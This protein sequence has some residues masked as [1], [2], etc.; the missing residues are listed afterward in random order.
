MLFGPIRETYSLV[1]ALQS[2][3]NASLLYQLVEEKIQSSFTKPGKDEWIRS[4]KQC[5]LWYVGFK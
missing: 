1:T 2:S 3:S 4:E 5:D